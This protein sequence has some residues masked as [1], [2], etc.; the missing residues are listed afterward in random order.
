[1][2]EYVRSGRARGCN[3][4]AIRWLVLSAITGPDVMISK[5]HACIWEVEPDGHV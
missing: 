3:R 2:V 4:S 5:L 1:M